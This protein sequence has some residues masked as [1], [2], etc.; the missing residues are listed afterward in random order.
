MSAQKNWQLKMLNWLKR[1]KTL[2]I[3]FVMQSEFKTLFYL[4]QKRYNQVFLIRSYF[5]KPKDI[6]SGD[7][8]WHAAVKTTPQDG[9]PSANIVVMAA[10]DCTGHGVPGAFMSIVGY[11]ILNQAM[12]EYKQI[13]PGTL[14]DVLNKGLSERLNQTMDDTRLRDGMDVALCMLNLKT[15][16]LQYAGAYNP[17]FVS[18]NKELIELKPDN[19]AIGSYTTSSVENYTNHQLQLQKG[20]TIY[21]F[22][23]GYTDQFGGPDGK[24]FELNQ[25]KTMLLSLDGVQWNNKKLCLKN[26]LK[27]GVV[28]FS[29]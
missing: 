10:V 22:T 25:L 20:D 3:A 29:K 18:R 26:Q 4:Q 14:L 23:D 27:N 13:T 5:F 8:Y 28:Y 12:K 2:P 24:K 9:K 7:F 19:I 1:I 11:D 17:L 21:A 15:L 6:V 16:E